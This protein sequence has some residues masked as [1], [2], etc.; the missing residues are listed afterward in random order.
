MN[1][2]KKK[3]LRNNNFRLLKS[4]RNIN[5]HKKSLTGGKETYFQ[6]IYDP[7]NNKWIKT[8]TKRG[9]KLLDIY[10]NQFTNT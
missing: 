7:I 3:R 5:T 4:K 9:N 8:N 1:V 6:N 2:S 10:I